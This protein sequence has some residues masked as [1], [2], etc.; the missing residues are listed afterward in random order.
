[1]VHFHSH[2]NHFRIDHLN[3]NGMGSFIT[4]IGSSAQTIDYSYRIILNH[5]PEGNG[6]VT[7]RNGMK[8][9]LII[10]AATNGTWKINNLRIRI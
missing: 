2:V 5:A 8:P 10:N 1:M 6:V 9:T 4:G 3:F 7:I